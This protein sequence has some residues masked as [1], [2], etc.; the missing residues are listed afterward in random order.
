MKKLTLLVAVA[1]STS[2][3]A[4]PPKK[5]KPGHSEQKVEKGI[6][7][8]KE[9]KEHP[10]KKEIV[11]P[12]QKLDPKEQIGQGKDDQKGK[13]NQGKENGK[14]NSNGK[15]N[16]G[17]D[18]DK[19]KGNKPEEHPGQGHAY[20]KNKGDLSGR[21]FGQQRAAEARAKHNE[22]K[23]KSEGEARELVKETVKRNEVLLTDTERKIRDFKTRLEELKKAGK[24]TTE[25]MN[26]KLKALESIEK[27]RATIE[28][29]ISN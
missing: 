17:K 21:E 24:I 20:G 22:A 12:N 14:G 6:E 26:L 29:K 27:R 28:L 7:G 23:P 4:Q 16:Q 10:G 8:K 9:E 19:D 3:M 18:K 2:V 15:G 25:E 1:I 13:P 5:E 11:K